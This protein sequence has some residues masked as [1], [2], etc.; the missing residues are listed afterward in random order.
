MRFFLFCIIDTRVIES[1]MFFVVKQ[2]LSSENWKGNHFFYYSRRRIKR[3]NICRVTIFCC[4]RNEMN[5]HKGS[6]QKKDVVSEGKIQTEEQ[7]WKRCQENVDTQTRYFIPIFEWIILFSARD[8]INVITP[9]LN[10][11]T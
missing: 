9:S 3:G 6:K 1:I 2:S 10:Y 8:S 11:M 4:C 7:L 5:Q